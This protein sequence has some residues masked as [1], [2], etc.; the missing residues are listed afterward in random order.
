MNSELSIHIVTYNHSDTI[1]ACLCRVLDI[2][3]PVTVTDNASVDGTRDI[4]SGLSEK[5]EHLSLNFLT[6]NIGFSGGHNLGIETA[7]KNGIKGLLILNPDAW[8]DKPSLES[9]WA[10]LK[11]DPRGI[12]ATP[13]IYRCG[14]DLQPQSDL[15]LDACG[16]YITPSLRHFDRGSG[17]PENGNYILPEYVFGATGACLLLKTESLWSSSIFDEDFFAYREDADFSWQAIRRGWKI[18]YVPTSLAWH[19][20]GLKE[21]SREDS[22]AFVKK[23]GVQNRF[24]LQFKNSSYKDNLRAVIPGSARNLLVICASLSIERTSFG[25]LVSSLN[26][27]KK[28]KVKRKELFSKAQVGG[29]ALGDWFSYTPQSQS[30]LSYLPKKTSMS[31]LKKSQAAIDNSSEIAASRPRV[32]A[33]IVSYHAGRE[34]NQLLNLLLEAKGLL[35][36]SCELSIHI[37]DNG[38]SSVNQTEEIFLLRP[39]TNLGFSGGINTLA[40][41]AKSADYFLILNPDIELTAPNLK[42]LLQALES[43]KRLAAVGPRLSSGANPESFPEAYWPKRERSK[44]ANACELLFLHKLFPNNPITQNYNYKDDRVISG[45]FSNETDGSAARLDDR[46]CLPVDHIPAACFLVRAEAFHE[47]NGFDERFWPAWFEDVDFFK[48]LRGAGHLVGY[49]GAAKVQHIGAGSLSHLSGQ[50]FARAWYGNMNLF[51]QKH[52]SVLGFVLFRVSF[53]LGVW[54]R[55]VKGLLSQGFLRESIKSLLS[56]NLPSSPQLR[57]Q[58]GYLKTLLLL[59]LSPN[60]ERRKFKKAK[61]EKYSGK[62]SK[63]IKKGL[64]PALVD[65]EPL[66][67]IEVASL[68]WREIFTNQLEGEGLELGPLHRPCPTHSKMKVRYVDRF[69]VAELREHYPELADLDLVESD[70]L[71]DAEK[72]GTLDSESFD[73]V[74]AAHIIEHTKN[75][76]ETFKNWLRVLKPG[77]LIYLIVPDKRYTFDKSRARTSLE[78]MILDYREPSDERDFIHFLD[79]AKKVGGKTGESAVKEAQDLVERDYSIHYH[80]FTPDDMTGLLEWFSKNIEPLEI[81]DGPCKSPQSDEFHYLLRKPLVDTSK[82]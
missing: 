39:K 28:F 71:D 27:K 78:H 29:K 58:L 41:E 40:S 57:S 47:L 17:M 19:Y 73:F 81:R 69:S 22:S 35:E 4:L 25:G 16:M 55:G 43:E 10:D 30:R 26:L 61:G 31:N 65:S 62:L 14:K 42:L 18:L 3:I 50:D 6:E 15:V 66:K 53:A 68:N 49:L 23:L 63:R 2:G 46:K 74:V 20:R 51:Y 7:L 11:A 60:Y 64:N 72:L 21:K 76:L 44:L 8:I 82:T 36:E 75:P 1:K 24:L 56:F 52:S 5:N 79:F 13:R 9:L 70:F 77:G 34:L 33:L 80:V 54:A 59:P 38:G 48:R 32:A 67:A 12:A 37:V 45:F